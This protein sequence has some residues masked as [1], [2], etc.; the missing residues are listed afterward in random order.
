MAAKKSQTLL[1]PQQTSKPRKPAVAQEMTPNSM[2]E[3]KVKGKETMKLQRSEGLVL[4]NN[5]KQKGMREWVGGGGGFWG[6]F[7]FRYMYV[8]M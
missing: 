7:L 5:H 6:V 4:S 8:C 3:K 1:V 2:L